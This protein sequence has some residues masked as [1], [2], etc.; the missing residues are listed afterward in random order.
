MPALRYLVPAVILV[1][2]L[3][4]SLSQAIAISLSQSREQQLF[5][6]MRI[7]ADIDG[8]SGQSDLS[9]AE[10]G[11]R[12]AV[13]RGLQK[14][15]EQNSDFVGWLRIQDSVIDYPVMK[16][17]E[18][19]PEYYLN[20]DFNGE[21]SSSGC[22]FVGAG[23]DLD[24]TVF[25]VYGH[26]M[27]NNTMLGTLDDYADYGYANG[28]QVIELKTPTEN[29]RYRVFAAFQSKVYAEGESGFRYYDCVGSLERGA[30][31]EVVQAIQG[32]SVVDIKNAPDYPQQILL[33]STCS[34][35]TDDGRFVV[36]AYREA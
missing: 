16:S 35:H 28:H 19:D 27:S 18:D 8:S 36:A 22:L 4:Y 30:Y 21:P 17:S 26:N 31:E 29:R 13:N 3:V 33:L 6:E 15:H 5:D 1:V 9:A 32:V 11:E 23:C 34:Y 12:R 24:S 2:I 7:V 14:L 10:A 20:R 25:V